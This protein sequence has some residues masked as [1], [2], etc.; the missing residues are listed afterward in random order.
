MGVAFLKWAWFQN[1]CAQYSYNP[2]ILKFL[3]PPLIVLIDLDGY[4]PNLL[5]SFA[6]VDELAKL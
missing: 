1:F 6:I 4:M 5:G 2:T 3:D